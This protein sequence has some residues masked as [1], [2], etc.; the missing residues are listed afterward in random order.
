MLLSRPTFSVHDAPAV[1]G[2][3]ILYVDIVTLI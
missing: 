3:C 1:E 2:D